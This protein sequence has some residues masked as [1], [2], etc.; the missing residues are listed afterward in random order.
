MKRLRD[1][2]T[3]LASLCLIAII[4]QL[5]LANR[6]CQFRD[7]DTAWITSEQ[8]S[9]GHDA[10]LLDRKAN[11]SEIV[12]QGLFAVA[13][14]TAIGSAVGYEIVSRKPDPLVNIMPDSQYSTCNSRSTPPH[15]AKQPQPL[16]PYQS[17]SNKPAP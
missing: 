17:Q 3:L 2:S 5:Y 1:I 16:D 9:D 4:A 10:C 6:H 14:L 8:K 12:A 13:F 15:S 7:S 11:P